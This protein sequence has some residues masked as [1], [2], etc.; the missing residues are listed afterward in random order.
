MIPPYPVADAL[1]VT[2]AVQGD[3]LTLPRPIRLDNGK[4]DIRMKAN[5]IGIREGLDDTCWAFFSIGDVLFALQYDHFKV[6]R[7]VTLDKTKVSKGMLVD[8]GL[9]VDALECALD[10]PLIEVCD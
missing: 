6:I 2:V 8:L 5:G 1:G 3:T 7:W 10:L 9:L 4:V